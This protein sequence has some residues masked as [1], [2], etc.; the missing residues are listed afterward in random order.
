MSLPLLDQHS[1][2]EVAA[3]AAPALAHLG[4]AAGTSVA[5]VAR[6]RPEL[7]V[8]DAAAALQGASVV[9]VDPD[10]S[11]IDADRALAEA[12]PSVV[13]CEHAEQVPFVRTRAPGA[14]VMVLAGTGT[15]AAVLWPQV[16]GEVGPATSPTGGAGRVLCDAHLSVSGSG[17][18]L[19]RLLRDGASVALAPPDAD[20]QA[21]LALRPTTL[22]T[23]SA[24]VDGLAR[25]LCRRAPV[26]RAGDRRALGWAAVAALPSLAWAV[27]SALAL[28][29]AGGRATAATLAALAFAAAALAV[30]RRRPVVLA[31]AAGAVLSLACDAAGS[32][33]SFVAAGR[34]TAATVPAAA[35]AVY[36]AGASREVA[37]AQAVASTRCLEN[38]RRSPAGI[39][40]AGI[41]RLVATRVRA[42][43]GLPAC[44]RV[45]VVGGAP[46]ERALAEL[47][48]TRVVIATV[49]PPVPAA[50]PRVLMSTAREVG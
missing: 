41:G 17:E 16:V 8:V 42:A 48:V 45:L 18:A 36:L 39:V 4:L 43:V 6:N 14:A 34:F 50:S 21:V 32:A 11:A 15:T 9:Q 35:L 5:V 25:E 28:G 13:V 40:N 49:D 20:R 3:R 23:T 10:G 44:R 26:R 27:S 47:A 24:R 37:W 31:V 46:D 22:L 7:L 1:L 33:P 38:A 30:G 19:R 12:R 29:S 2:D